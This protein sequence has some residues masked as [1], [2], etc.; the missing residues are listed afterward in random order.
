MSVHSLV[1]KDGATGEISAPY[2]WTIR[3]GWTE[4][5]DAQTYGQTMDGWTDGLT[6]GRTDRSAVSAYAGSVLRRVHLAVV[7]VRP[8]SGH[9]PGKR[10]ARHSQ[11]SQIGLQLTQP[12]SNPVALRLGPALR[13]S[14]NQNPMAGSSVERCA[15]CP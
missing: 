1:K 6:D 14:T 3:H 11:S 13:I 2:G 9:S 8:P 12:R 4:Q 10:R 7:L 5:M 15:T